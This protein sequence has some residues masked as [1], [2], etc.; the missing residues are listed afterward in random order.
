M[1]IEENNEPEINEEE[2]TFEKITFDTDYKIKKYLD[3]PP[4]NLELKPLPDHLEYAFLEEH[5]FLLVIISSQ[6]SEQNENKLIYVL[7]RHKQAFAWK[8]TDNPAQQN[9]TVPEK[10]L[11]VAVFA[12]DKFKPYLVLSKTVVYT[13]HSA[14]IHLFKKQD[15]KPHLIR[16]ILLLQEFDT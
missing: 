15:A 7:K 2:I 12:F 5:S 4:T 13:A 16:W 3:E 10:E 14:L 11:M 9:Y 8:T 6:L 1:N